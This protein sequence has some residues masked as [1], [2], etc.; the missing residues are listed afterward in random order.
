MTKKSLRLSYISEI[1][2]LTTQSQII[3]LFKY[4]LYGS[5]AFQLFYSNELRVCIL[6]VGMQIVLNLWYIESYFL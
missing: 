6:R 5:Y 1:I 2:K 3:V 4:R